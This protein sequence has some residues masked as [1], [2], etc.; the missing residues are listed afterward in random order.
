M[1]SPPR[2]E[3]WERLRAAGVAQGEPP[4]APGEAP[5]FVRLMLG[6]AGWIGAA[7]LLGFFGVALAHLLRSPGSQLALGALLCA[8]VAVAL[9]AVRHGD[10]LGQFALAVSLT[11]QALMASG[12]E[13]ALGMPSAAGAVAAQQAILFVMISGTVH[14]TWCAFSGGYALVIA[15]HAW[16]LAPFAGPLLLAASALAWLR[17]LEHP[18]EA[19]LLRA[20]GYGLGVAAFLASLGGGAWIGALWLRDPLAPGAAG[21]WSAI[22]W[23]VVVLAAAAALLRREGVPLASADGALAMAGAL[24]VAAAAARAPGIAPATGLLVLGYANGNRVLAGLGIAALIGY[25]AHYYYSLHAT[26]LVKSQL[27]AAA[28]I[29]LL[30][31]R[32]AMRRLSSGRQARDA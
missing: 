7:F 3:L 16:G 19:G 4:E 32:Y 22:A 8:A 15:L 25:L 9:R 6:I 2:D 20:A 11:G 21:L 28:G 24:I 17:E 10:L 12:L 13:D 30:A 1:S 31:A 26:L 18:R 5:W 14:R 29:A 23:G 27:L